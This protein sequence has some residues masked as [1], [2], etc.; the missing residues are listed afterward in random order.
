MEIFNEGEVMANNKELS[1]N[2]LINGDCLNIMP[3]IKDKSVNMIL[4]DLPYG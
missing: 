3:Y 4:C 2:S 1:A